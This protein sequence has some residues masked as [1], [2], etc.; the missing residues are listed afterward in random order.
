MILLQRFIDRFWE[1]LAAALENGPALER[2]QQLLC[3]LLE[4][5]KGTYVSQISRAGIEGLMDELDQ[6]TLK[7]GKTGPPPPAPE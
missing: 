1:E 7:G 3:A 2:S 4:E 6:L 5:V